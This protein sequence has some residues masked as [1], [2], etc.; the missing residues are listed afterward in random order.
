M[1]N[2]LLNVVGVFVGLV[3]GSIV[4][5]SLVNVG[6][7]IVPPPEGVDMTTVEGIREAMPKLSVGNLMFPFLGHALGTLVG[8][9]LAAKIAASHKMKFAVGIGAFYLLGGLSMVVMVGG[10]MWFMVTDL[11]IAYLPM[12]WLGG[13]LAAPKP[14][15]DFKSDEGDS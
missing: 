5:L 10:P 13:L 3:V 4:N 2:I 1:K 8:A 11:V 14:R 12:G 7:M 6:P 15:G 9:F